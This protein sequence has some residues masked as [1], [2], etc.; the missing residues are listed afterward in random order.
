MWLYILFFG[1]S[2][3]VLLDAQN[4]GVRKGQVK[5]LADKNPIGWFVGCL[6]LWVVIFPF[7]LFEV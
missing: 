4:I 5:G 3:W 6:L 7:N 1:T 2:L